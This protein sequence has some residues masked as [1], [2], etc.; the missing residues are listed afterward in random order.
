MQAAVAVLAALF[1]IG[2]L[3]VRVIKG[4]PIK[5]HMVSYGVAV[6]AAVFTYAYFLGMDIPQLFKIAF[7]ILLGIVL[8]IAAALYQRR[9]AEK[10]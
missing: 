3:V 7:S 9:N 1:L 5:A 6:V 8:I 4:K 2:W 10:S